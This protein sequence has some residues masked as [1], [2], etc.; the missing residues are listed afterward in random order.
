MNK[1]FS[2]KLIFKENKKT[3]LILI[4]NLKN[5]KIWINLINSQYRNKL[6]KKVSLIK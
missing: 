6:I 4:M 1:Q 3:N 5:W 2:Q